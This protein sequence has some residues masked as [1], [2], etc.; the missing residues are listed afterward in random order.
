MATLVKGNQG[1]K[2]ILILIINLIRLLFK[3]IIRFL[4]IQFHY[5]KLN[6]KNVI[7]LPHIELMQLFLRSF[8]PHILRKLQ[9]NR[10]PK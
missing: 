8:P 6:F 4:H 5:Y 9:N 1:E 7:F 2:R 3:I 10:S